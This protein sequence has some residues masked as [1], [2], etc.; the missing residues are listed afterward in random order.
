MGLQE[1]LDEYNKK[2]KEQKENIIQA[3][4]EPKEKENKFNAAFDELINKVIHPN[5][6]GIMGK[7]NGDNSAKEIS[8]SD[9]INNLNYYLSMLGSAVS[10][11]YYFSINN[12]QNNASF[13]NINQLKDI[14]IFKIL[15][16][17]NPSKEK[18]IIVID[19][20]GKTPNKSEHDLSKVNKE[21]LESIVEEAF[22]E[23]IS[24]K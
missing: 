22:L 10:K 3:I 7:F 8:K 13:Q 16:G 17:R 12:K 23:I 11:G 6:E 21:L 18:V 5:M 20:F 9:L 4:N 2:R 24:G 14:K 15:F 1:S 19:I